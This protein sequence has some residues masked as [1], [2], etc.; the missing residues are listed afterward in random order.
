M[1]HE[2]YRHEHI[3]WLTQHG[4]VAEVKASAAI[5]SVAMLLVAVFL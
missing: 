1:D 2:T 4:I 5:L 3:E